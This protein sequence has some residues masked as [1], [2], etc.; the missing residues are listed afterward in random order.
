MTA[1]VT[2]LM[3][4]ILRIKAYMFAKEPLCTPSLSWGAA[5]CSA[6]HGPRTSCNESSDFFVGA[7]SGDLPQLDV[8]QLVLA[9]ELDGQE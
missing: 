8:V 6:P 1:R 7:G 9:E 4:A 3:R 5:K 2:R